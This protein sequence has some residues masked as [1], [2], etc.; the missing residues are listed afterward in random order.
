MTIKLG[1]LGLETLQSRSGNPGGE[2]LIVPL[3]I[4]L[5]WIGWTARGEISEFKKR[6]EMEEDDIGE[7][8]SD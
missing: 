3:M 1:I 5:V 2:I 4:L 7:S 8:E 6:M